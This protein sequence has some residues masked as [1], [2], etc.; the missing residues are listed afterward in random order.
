[1]ARMHPTLSATL[2]Y[3]RCR[4]ISFIRSSVSA[5]NSRSVL[6]IHCAWLA[7]WPQTAHVSR[8]SGLATGVS[9]GCS[10][11]QCEQIRVNEGMEMFAGASNDLTACAVRTGHARALTHRCDSGVASADGRWRLRAGDTGLGSDLIA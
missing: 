1:M 10:L 11:P 5:A 8:V 6:V 4:E 7:A 3:P 9:S 2:A